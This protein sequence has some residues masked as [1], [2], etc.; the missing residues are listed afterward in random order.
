[1]IV[2]TCEIEL[3]I[4]ESNSLKDKRQV[5]KSLIQRIKSRFNVSISEIDYLDLW[6]RSLIGVAVVSNSKTICES[7]ID[8]IISFID[9][10][11][12]VEITNYLIE[13]L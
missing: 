5:I 9:N 3:F 10:D 11:E 2:G 7:S 12:R 8:K 6:N 4:F 13:V 1:M